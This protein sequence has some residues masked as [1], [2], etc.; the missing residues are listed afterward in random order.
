[1]A[2]ILEC[3]DSIPDP[4]VA[5]KARKAIQVLRRTCA[6][7]PLDKI[8]F[9]FNG[10]KDSTVILHLLR[11]AVVQQLG[12][13]V[14]GL[15]G[16]QSFYF[17]KADDF[18][19]VKQFVE[20]ADA[21][22]GLGVD[23]L[24]D[25][26]FKTGLCDYLTRTGVMSIVLG[27]R[28]GDPNASGQDQFC[29][30]S[31]GWP[32]FMR[33]NPVIDWTYHDVWVFLRAAKVSYCILY[34]RG[35]TSLGSI[36]NTLPNSSL[37]RPDGAFEPA[38]H[39]AD[40]RLERMG[41]LHPAPAPHHPHPH[42]HPHLHPKP[43]HG[44]QGPH[45]QGQGQRHGPEQRGGSGPLA[46]PGKPAEDRAAGG[47]AGRGR[48]GA[49]AGAG[50]AEAGSGAEGDGEAEAG[51]GAESD[52]APEGEDSAFGGAPGRGPG[53]L[54]GSRQ[55]TTGAGSTGGALVS[56]LTR[57]AAI[58][59]VGDELLSGKV[60][61]VNARYLCRELRSMGWQVLRIVFVPDTVDE[62]ASAVRA[63]AA[64]VELVL[65]AGG[66]GPTVDDVTMEGIALAVGQPLVRLPDM[67]DR[68]A[69]YFGGEAALTPAH[70]KMAEG[71][72]N[73]ELIDYT[74]PDSHEPSRFP[75]FRVNNIYVL[76]GVPS[77]LVQKW[78]A[79]KPRL[80]DSA[81][82]RF[83][84]ATLRLSLTDETTIAPA[85]ER[86][87][88]THGLDVA[89]GSYPVDQGIIITLDSKNNQALQAAVADLT[90]LLPGDSVVS[91]ERDVDS[92]Q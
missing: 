57:S 17:K 56:E 38:Y 11:A 66:I 79:L 91:L 33:V 72:Q 62:I 78:A 59:I 61:D 51:A 60:E 88:S 39:L 63:L 20:S 89:V 23:Y 74:L 71:P 8:A 31:D 44:S 3:L 50:A 18:E 10:G 84:N 5:D 41:R 26:D 75:I 90:D 47:A 67:V 25:P 76:P 58:V 15:G 29:P 34:D 70:L 81:L 7:H 73:A 1:M 2:D 16:I 64:V 22:Y 54:S 80:E 43:G 77:L 83:R 9:S 69:I 49:A 21:Q 14:Q 82:A 37:L 12:P 55:R 28:R 27:T 52:I 46:G 19:E 92:L 45:G 40:G 36:K 35:Y 85:L 42:P 32:P 65:T 6:L 24:T 4:V 30:S 13:D 87:A 48:G 86:V 68:L 53:G